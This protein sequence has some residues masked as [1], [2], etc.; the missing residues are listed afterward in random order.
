MFNSFMELAKDRYSVRKYTEEAVRQEDLDRILEAG[1]VAPTGHDNQ[2]FRIVV[3]R[4]EEGVEKLKKI[5]RCDFGAKT[6]LMVCY[7]KSEA[8]ERKYD[9]YRCGETDAAIVTAHMQLEAWDIGVASCWVHFFRPEVA[10]TELNIPEQ[11]VPADILV[12]GYAAEDAVPSELHGRRK[13]AEDLV[14][15]NTL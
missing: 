3:L 2:P 14:F 13:K 11:M 7:D 9:G 6:A 15:E 5:T 12:L 8:W 1:I 4:G 10:R